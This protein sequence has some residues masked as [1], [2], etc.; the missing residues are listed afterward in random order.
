MRW[1]SVLELWPDL[2]AQVLLVEK[3]RQA[4]AENVAEMAG[5][6]ALPC[7][8]SWGAWSDCTPDASGPWPC[9][10]EAVGRRQRRWSLPAWC[11]GSHALLSDA[12]CAIRY[13]VFQPAQNGGGPC[14]AASGAVEPVNCTLPVH[15][16]CAPGGPEEGPEPA[17]P[18]PAPAGMPEPAVGTSLWEATAAGLWGPPST[19]RAEAGV[20]WSQLSDQVGAAQSI[21]ATQAQ[22]VAQARCAGEV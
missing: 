9:G 18:V 7:D 1:A 4:L 3:A 15:S 17:V 22:A 5:L 12:T 10:V 21:Q 19:P 20:L 16:N 11:C 8:G 2:F 14:A 6:E 13:T